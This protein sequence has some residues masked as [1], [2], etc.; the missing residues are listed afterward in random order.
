MCVWGG[1]ER[2]GKERGKRQLKEAVPQKRDIPLTEH[3]SEVSQGSQSLKSHHK[4]E[5]SAEGTVAE[6]KTL[7][8]LSR[9]SN[10][11]DPCRA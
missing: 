3:G 5:E 2:K 7:Q 4:E 1:L 10:L 11:I 9:D 6:V 8:S